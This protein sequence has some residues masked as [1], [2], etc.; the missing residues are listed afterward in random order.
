ML[1][2][3]GRISTTME[4]VNHRES[5][6]REEI[7]EKKYFDLEQQCNSEIVRN[8]LTKMVEARIEVQQLDKNDLE[9]EKIWLEKT[10]NILKK[11]HLINMSDLEKDYLKYASK[12]ILRQRSFINKTKS[13]FSK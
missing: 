6:T 13:I 4:A 7:E 1:N 5:M 12:Y 8:I 9:K 10:T 2:L 3:R 11:G